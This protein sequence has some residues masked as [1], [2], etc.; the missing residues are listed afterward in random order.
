M[1][2]SIVDLRYKMK[3][4]LQSLARSED[5]KIYY[6]N[7]WIGTIVP[8]RAGRKLNK[9][10]NHPFFGMHADVKKSVEEEMET[11]RG[12]RYS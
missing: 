9:V 10:R 2:A 12:G 6:H 3:S 1:K 5:V 4:V 11:L 7:K 8:Q